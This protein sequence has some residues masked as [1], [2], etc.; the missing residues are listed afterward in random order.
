MIDRD[1]IKK[2]LLEGVCKVTFEKTNG[3]L[4]VMNCTLNSNHIPISPA[5]EPSHKRLKA[6]NPEVQPVYD[7]KA[8]GWRSFRWDSIKEFS[9]E[10]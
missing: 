9:V 4:R 6:E 8:S 2:S 1:Q 5:S 10:A 3:E 7:V